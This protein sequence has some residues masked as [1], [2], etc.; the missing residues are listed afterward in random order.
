MRDLLGPPAGQPGQPGQPGAARAVASDTEG[1]A[2]LARALSRGNGVIRVEP[3]G[4]FRLFCGRYREPV[5]GACMARSLR[6]LGGAG[7]LRLPV[8]P[9]GVPAGRRALVRYRLSPRA[10]ASLRAA[11][12]VP[13]RGTVVARDRAGN[14]TRVTFRFVLRA[15]RADE[16][17]RPHTL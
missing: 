5:S 8:K 10:L 4:R 14:A 6:P 17:P 3:H 16:M 7:R 9:F 13:M 11:E 2:I 12:R 15:P 1:P